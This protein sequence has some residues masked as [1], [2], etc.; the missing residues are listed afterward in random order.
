MEETDALLRRGGWK[1]VDPRP[2][3]AEHPDTFELPDPATLAALEPG[4]VV[5][6]MFRTAT[7]ADVSRDGFGPYDKQGRP[8]LVPITERM[9]GIVISVDGDVLEC[10]LD[11][12]P[13]ATHTRLLPNDRVR[14]P[15][16]HVIATG[17]PIPDL[18][19]FL[20]F[21]ERWESDPE[22]P[23]EPPTAPVDPLAPPRIR[24]DQQQ[25]CDRVGVKAQPPFP[26]GYVLLGNDVTPESTLV[27]G[28]R[29]DPDRERGDC[30]WIVY[31]GEADFETMAQTV[32]CQV[33]TLQRALQAHPGILPYVALPPGWGFTLAGGADDVYP[34]TVTDD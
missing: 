33:V 10:A 26:F 1:L 20:E 14:I 28:A 25:V 3:A 6:A 9:W 11:N 15:V 4:S 23:A 29:F 16:T 13:M 17:E 12:L 30:G 22:A 18:G 34:I 32:G 5:R 31:A 7:I 24:T 19:Q 21:L 2:I 8:V 27:H